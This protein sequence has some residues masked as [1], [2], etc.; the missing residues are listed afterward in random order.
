AEASA[1]RPVRDVPF[2]VD[3]RRGRGVTMAKTMQKAKT[4]QNRPKPLYAVAGAADIAVSTLR[5]LPSRLPSL[6]E[7]AESATASA[8][9][10]LSDLSAE[11]PAELRRL[12]ADLP[13]EFRRL[14]SELPDG[15]RKIRAELPER[16]HHA[17]TRAEHYYSELADRGE[18]VVA[19]LRGRE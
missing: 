9:S 12:R 5:R 11:L 1:A 8:R 7:R 15:V 3:A 10:R 4:M 19:R 13:A 14:Q 6:A 16:L 2:R 17:Q 18:T